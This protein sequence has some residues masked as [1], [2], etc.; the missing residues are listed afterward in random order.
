M[1]LLYTG[2]NQQKRNVIFK[3]V[4]VLSTEKWRKNLDNIFVVAAVLTDVFKGFESV[5]HDLLIAKLS[6]Y[7]FSDKTLSYHLFI[8]D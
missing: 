3:P 2:K 7:N 5:P 8:P 1:T 6:V 4:N